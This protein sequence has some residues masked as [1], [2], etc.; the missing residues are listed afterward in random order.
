[1]RRTILGCVGLVALGL[2]FLALTL[3]A[4]ILALLNRL[5]WF[6][7]SQSGRGRG[8]EGVSLN[9]YDVSDALVG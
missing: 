6:L 8:F 7:L 9:S 2:I 1:V 5:L 3:P 4:L